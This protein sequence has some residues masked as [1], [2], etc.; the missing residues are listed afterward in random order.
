MLE[1]NIRLRLR[2]K[3][4]RD[5]GHSPSWQYKGLNTYAIKLSSRRQRV[6]NLIRGCCTLFSLWPAYPFVSERSVSACCQANCSDGPCLYN[7]RTSEDD[8]KPTVNDRGCG[9]WSRWANSQK[10]GCGHG[11]Q[12]TIC[13]V[14]SSITHPHRCRGIVPTFGMILQVYA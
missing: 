14:L 4:H 3:G 7:H 9:L 8:T 6:L 11:Q 5:L 1:P 10:R 12:L 13:I 2:S